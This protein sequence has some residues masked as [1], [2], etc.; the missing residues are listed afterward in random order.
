MRLEPQVPGQH[1][2]LALTTQGKKLVP[3]LAALAD[4]ND[5]EFFDCLSEGERQS[6]ERIL[7]HMVEHGRMTAVPI[8]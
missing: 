8:D 2:T 1:Q 3:D 6:L 7:K 5:R 4:Q